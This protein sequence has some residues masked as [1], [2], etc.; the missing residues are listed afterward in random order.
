MTTVPCVANLYD[1]EADQVYLVPLDV[2][3]FRATDEELKE[4]ARVYSTWGIYGH[5]LQYDMSVMYNCFSVMPHSVEGDS[6][7]VSRILQWNSGKL[8]DIAREK[9]P[10][11][12]INDLLLSL[13]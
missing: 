10:K 11:L 9:Y 5:Y 1:V 7:L 13:M 6:Y 2:S 3:G 8:K 12:I 4:F